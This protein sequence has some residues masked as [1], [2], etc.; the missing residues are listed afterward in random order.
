M[1]DVLSDVMN[2]L[3]LESS[4]YFR[5]ELSAPFSIEVPEDASVVRFHVASQGSFI[6]SVESEPPVEVSAGDLV[7]IP[8][9]RRH[10]LADASGPDPSSLSAVLESSSFDG[11]G[12]LVYGGD[13]AQTTL[14]CGHVGF[15][16]ELTHPFIETLPAILHLRKSE[17]PDYSWVEKMLEFAEHE[18][19]RQPTGWEGVVER[20][21]Q[22]LFVYVLRAHMEKDEATSGALGALADPQLAAALQAIHGD[23]AHEWSLDTLAQRAGMSRSVFVRRFTAATGVAPMKYL[24]RWRMSR[25]NFLLAKTT[26]SVG[27]VASSVGYASEAAFNRV[28]KEHF[29]APPATFRKQL[30]AREAAAAG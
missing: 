1:A 10:I 23:P 11:D 19:R 26:T 4:V 9:G 30:R 13:G 25:A 2:T 17:G 29:E 16:T 28:F 7:L 14:V 3:Q 21:S 15:S 20:L 18:S 8:H 12:P 22:I 24:T 6:V 27:D 5:A